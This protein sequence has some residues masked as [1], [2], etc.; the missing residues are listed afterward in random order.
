MVAFV[1]FGHRH[2]AKLSRSHHELYCRPSC[3]SASRSP[4]LALCA[5][6]RRLDHVVETT[7]LD[8]LQAS[9]RASARRSLCQTQESR[10]TSPV[11]RLLSV[12]VQASICAELQFATRAEAP[13]ASGST[14]G[15]P[16]SRSK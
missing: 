12:W 14:S 3:T 13:S 7:A 9:A 16:K 4:P 15:S 6:R 2:E 1:R 10:V 5:K 8:D 11:L